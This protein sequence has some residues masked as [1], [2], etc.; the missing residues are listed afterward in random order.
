MAYLLNLLAPG[1]GHL[2]SGRWMVGPLL[3]LLWLVLET[4]VFIAASFEVWSLLALPFPW[5]L[6]SLIS[7]VDLWRVRRKPDAK[8]AGLLRSLLVLPLPPILI[9][10]TV[11]AVTALAVRPVTIRSGSMTPS[12]VTG[13]TILVQLFRPLIRDLALGDIVLVAHPTQQGRNLIKRILGMAGDL[14]EIRS[15]VLH[16]NG[17]ALSNCRLRTLRD[18]ET[19]QQVIERLEV[20]DGHPYL[21]WDLPAIRSRAL[22]VRVP[23]GHIFAVGDNR[24]RSGD[25]R[26]FGT[27]PVGSVRGLVTVRVAP[28]WTNNLFEAPLRARQAASER[29]S[30][31][32]GNARDEPSGETKRPQ[33]VRGRGQAW[34]ETR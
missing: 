17:R 9:V 5:L 14:I 21:V 27:V 20:L 4:A 3:L 22:R 30:S 23:D 11:L 19:H 6:L 13:D 18:H 1:L 12:V 26:T 28:V 10:V 33:R 31:R 34:P 7:L 32:N 24:D 25:S 16:R 15:G 29:C 2:A 8:K